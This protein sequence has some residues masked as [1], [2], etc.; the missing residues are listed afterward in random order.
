M[1]TYIEL[2]HDVHFK[3]GIYILQNINFIKFPLWFPTRKKSDLKE[4][5]NKFTKDIYYRVYCEKGLP[6]QKD[7]EILNT[8]LWFYLKSLNEIYYSTVTN[9]PGDKFS[10]NEVFEYKTKGQH[11]KYVEKKLRF[12]RFKLLKN[13]LGITCNLIDLSNNIGYNNAIYKQIIEESLDKWANIEIEYSNCYYIDKGKVTSKTFKN[14]IQKYVVNKN[15]VVIIF[16]QDFIKEFLQDKSWCV[17]DYS[18]YIKLSNTSRRLYEY[19]ILA[20]NVI[21]MNIKLFYRQLGL[22][23]DYSISKMVRILN[24]AIEE[25]NN[26]TKLKVIKTNL[27]ELK[28]KN[29]KLYIKT[30]KTHV[31]Y[32]KIIDYYDQIIE[33][34]LKFYGIYF[35]DIKGFDKITK[36]KKDVRKNFIEDIEFKSYYETKIQEFKQLSKVKPTKEHT[37]EKLKKKKIKA[38]NK[39]QKF[40]RSLLYV[41]NNQDKIKNKTSYLN[42]CLREKSFDKMLSNSGFSGVIMKRFYTELLQDFISNSV[43]EKFGEVN[44]AERI[45]LDVL[46]KYEDYYKEDYNKYLAEFLMVGDNFSAP[47]VKLLCTIKY[48]ITE[49]TSIKNNL[50]SF[51]YFEKLVDLLLLL[52]F[53]NSTKQKSLFIC[54]LNDSVCRTLNYESFVYLYDLFEQDDDVYEFLENNTINTGEVA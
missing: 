50:V 19:L 53:I 32:D 8:L 45:V 39:L 43:L 42:A 9:F 31:L 30:E 3:N 2:L 12:D 47:L 33:E 38:I 18:E 26:H 11:N 54:L 16:N 49:V 5:V 6:R 4:Y 25:I 51:Y 27:N 44:F 36:D 41:L 24:K 37:N 7:F 1:N 48:L 13:G 14:I 28:G 40:S 29:N 34:I 23:G 20:N 10:E 46:N 21:S 52:K 35:D 15:K 22:T 17:I